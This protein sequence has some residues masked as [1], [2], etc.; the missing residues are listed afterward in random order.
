MT[1]LEQLRQE[2]AVLNKINKEQQETI[3]DQERRLEI[4][5]EMVKALQRGNV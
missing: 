3:E 5:D 4:K 2:V 1:E